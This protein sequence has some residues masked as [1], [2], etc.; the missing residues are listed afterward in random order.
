MLWRSLWFTASA[1]MWMESSGEKGRTCVQ[2]VGGGWVPGGTW[3][4]AG[5]SRVWLASKGAAVKCPLPCSQAPVHLHPSG[6]QAHILLWPGLLP[7][8]LQ[9]LTPGLCLFLLAFL[10]TS[11]PHSKVHLPPDQVGL[12]EAWCQGPKPNLPVPQ[13]QGGRV[14]RPS[15]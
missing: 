8:T 5:L 2:A 4:D 3:H 1:G 15:H 10:L 12:Q 6:P 11:T 14:P 7:A 13:A 9:G